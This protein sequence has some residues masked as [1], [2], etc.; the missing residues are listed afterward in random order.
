MRKDGLNYRKRDSYFAI[1]SA[2][3]LG[4]A[5]LAVGLLSSYFVVIP[6]TV[7]GLGMLLF[8]GELGHVVSSRSGTI[9][10]WFKEEGDAISPGE[11]IAEMVDHDSEKVIE[12]SARQHGIIAEIT[13]FSDTLVQ[14]GQTLAI[15]SHDGDPR[16]DLELTGFVSSLDGKK[17]QPG[18]LALIDPTTTNAA[19]HGQLMARVKK[20]GKLPVTKAA[21]S[22]ILKISEV[23]DFIRNQIQAEPFMVILEPIKNE[24]TSSGYSWTGP[25]PSSVLDSGVFAR[26]S[27]VIDERRLLGMLLPTPPSWWPRKF[28]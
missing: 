13:S 12:I 27:V 25:G 5:L 24:S 9:T 22:S 23:A 26:M 16:R 21:I 8:K 2:L 10:S 18:M 7:H 28:Q 1:T 17:I 15:I 11:K 20:V 3:L 19:Q 4:T 6:E 14:R